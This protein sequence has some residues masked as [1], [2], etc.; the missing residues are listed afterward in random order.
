[1]SSSLQTGITPLEPSVLKPILEALGLDEQEFDSS[2]VALELEGRGEAQG[3]VLRGR[4]DEGLDE[5]GTLLLHVTG[6]SEETDLASWRN[7]L[8][9]LCHTVAILRTNSNGELTRRTLH[10]KEDLGV[11]CK[12]DG[13][14]LVAQR[15]SHVLAPKKTIEKFDGTAAGW[16]GFEGTPGYPHHRWMRRF[17][18]NFAET[19]GR[20]RILDFGCGAGWVGIEAAL[21]SPGCSLSAFDPSPAM[22]EF[23]SKNA[24]AAGIADFTGRTGFGEEPPFPASGEEPYDLVISSGV[25]SFAR[26]ADAWFE[27]LANA[28]APGGTLVIGDIHRLSRGMRHRR[29]TRALL[30]IREMNAF[31]REE[32][33]AELER[34][35]FKHEVSC[36]YQLTT[37]VPQAMHFSET[38]LGGLLTW[39]ILIAN[40]AS[41][42]LDRALGSPLQNQF[43]SWVMRF[44][45]PE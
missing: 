6:A 27:G 4:V 28:T 17:V 3:S 31:T 5:D 19:S 22:V 7:S 14:V 39:P 10:G 2:G 34:R 30:P 25:I 16:N 9:P 43:D 37:P 8:W 23:T 13:A 44:K 36:G 11:K 18:G 15:K 41:A 45:A 1:M 40:M 32:A 42:G 29:R 21:G 26:D 20:K 12:L 24:K 33:R 35:G 38:R